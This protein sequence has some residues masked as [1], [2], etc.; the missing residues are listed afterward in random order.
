[1]LF[2]WP[3]MLYP[4]YSL[5]L[6][7]PFCSFLSIGWYCRVGVFGLIGCISLSLSLALPTSFTNNNNNSNIN[8]VVF[9][10]ERF[11]VFIAQGITNVGEYLHKLLSSNNFLYPVYLLQHKHNFFFLH[12]LNF[13]L[14]NPNEG[15]WI[16]LHFSLVQVHFIFCL[17][18][19]IVYFPYLPYYTYKILP[20]YVY[21]YC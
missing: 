1:M 6:F 5:L 15:G 3:K 13:F 21:Y 16:I 20:Y 7:F 11:E 4:Y 9:S 14:L 8:T 10:K 18:N 17:L 19:F 2:Y 12:T